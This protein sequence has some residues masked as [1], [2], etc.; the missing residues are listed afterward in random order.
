MSDGRR[1]VLDPVGGD[2]E[3]PWTH[4]EADLG[5]VRL[6]YVARGEGP[7]VLLLHGF[8]EFW[9]SW[10]YQI[11]PLAEAGFRVVAPSMR[12]YGRSSKPKGVASY[13]LR[14]LV[15]DADA[16]IRHLG[17]ESAAVVG[18]DWGGVVGFALASRRPERVRRLAVVNA[19]HPALYRKILRHPGQLLR[20]WYALAFQLPWLPERAFRIYDYELVE[21]VL[22]R[23]IRRPDVLEETDFSAY[24]EA[25]GEPGAVPAMI[26][27]YRA[28]FRDALRHLG[29][30]PRADS[31]GRIEQETL[32][33]WGEKDRYLSRRLLYGLERLIPRLWMELL[34]DAG[35]FV[36]QE[37]HERVNQTLLWFLGR[38]E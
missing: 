22:R 19:P 1:P 20:S 18:H 24:A 3:R 35:H 26:H 27:Y 2:P 34:G 12:G 15:D 30:T 31:A 37:A 6:H 32:V 7:L 5:E 4:H 36:H 38:E 28:A 21:R 8:P 11:V 16:L 14:H 13:R 17:E 33:V 25:L 10:R 9:Y 23:D 29:R